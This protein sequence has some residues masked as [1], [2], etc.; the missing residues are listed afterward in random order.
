MEYE[1]I[2]V[3]QISATAQVKYTDELGRSVVVPVQIPII[4][5]QYVLDERFDSLLKRVAPLD[6]FTRMSAMAS[7]GPP[8]VDIGVK[9]AFTPEVLSQEKMNDGAALGYLTR[10]DW[11]VIREMET[12]T[13]VPADVLQSRQLAR[14]LIV[15]ST[16]I[17][18]FNP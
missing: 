9:V 17:L 13:P 7:L 2:G 3:E 15:N 8:T 6:V 11:L 16:A 12:G 4:N 10:T 18:P 1:I 5:G 14:S